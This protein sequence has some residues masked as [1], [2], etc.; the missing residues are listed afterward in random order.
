MRWEKK[1]GGK[2]ERERDRQKERERIVEMDGLRVH[3]PMVYGPWFMVYSLEVR[4]HAC[5]VLSVCN[6]NKEK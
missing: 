6:A 2:R 3:H 1:K 4:L 5:D